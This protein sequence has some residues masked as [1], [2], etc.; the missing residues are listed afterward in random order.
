[1]T[2]TALSRTRVTAQQAAAEI[3]VSK[4]AVTALGVASALV[5]LWAVACFVGGMLASGGPIDMARA[6]ISAVTGA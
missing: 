5:G 4:G 1:M 6:W 2:N 3:N